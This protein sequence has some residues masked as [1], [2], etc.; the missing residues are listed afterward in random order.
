MRT[1]VLYD[2]FTLSTAWESNMPKANKSAIH[3]QEAAE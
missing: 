2:A 3:V 1:F